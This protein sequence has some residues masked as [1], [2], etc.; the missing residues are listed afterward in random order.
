MTLEITGL[1]VTA[2][3]AIFGSVTAPVILM[4]RTAAMHREDRDADWARQDKLAAEANGKLDTIHKLVDGAFTAAMR[5]ELGA[6]RRE[7][8]FDLVVDTCGYVPA[9]VARSAE[10]LVGPGR[11]ADD[12]QFR[13]CLLAVL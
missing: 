13:L 5:A 2:L 3:L 1:I 4:N 7:L 6:T 10:A 9:D 11:R 12:G 8:A